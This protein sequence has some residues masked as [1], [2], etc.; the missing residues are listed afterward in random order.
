MAHFADRVC[1][2]PAAAVTK[3]RT[4]GGSNSTSG[5]FCSSG[6]QNP[7]ANRATFLLE[8]SGEN[9]L[10]AA[11]SPPPSSECGTPTFV[12]ISRLLCGPDLPVPSQDPRGHSSPWRDQDSP[13]RSG[14]SI[15]SVELFPT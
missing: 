5:C 9:L 3:C 7:G 8:V 6:A 12:S 13:R 11:C 1:A 2:L 15:T 14:P 4:V 10:E